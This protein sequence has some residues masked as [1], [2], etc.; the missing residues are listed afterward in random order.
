MPDYSKGKIYKLVSNVC[1]DVYVGSTTQSLAK[2]VGGHRGAY[3]KFL[4]GKYHWV[5]SFKLLEQGSVD[6]VL[7]ENFPCSSKDELHARERHWIEK[8]DCV[9][10][11]IPGR[12]DAE[13]RQDNREAIAERKKQYH[14]DNR[15]SILEHKKQYRQANREAIR[16]QQSN[17]YQENREALCQ[18]RANYRQENCEAIRAQQ[19]TKNECPCGGRYTTSHK[20][21]HLKTKKHQAFVANPPPAYSP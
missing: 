17:Y 11:C 15:E 7:I 18:R 3:R 9:N 4:N 2:R 16:V 21:A 8:L 13:Y 20:A 10:R 19:K 12:T 5:T 6:I 14:Q 1:D